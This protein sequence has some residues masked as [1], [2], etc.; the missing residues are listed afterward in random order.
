[1]TARPFARKALLPALL[2][3]GA[4]H[5]AAQQREPV[6]TTVGVPAHLDGVVLPGSE[7]EAVP[8]TQTSKVVVRIADVN[9]HG[10]AHRYDLEFVGLEAGEYDL[11]AFLQRKDR[12][13]NGPLPPLP[14][15]VASVLPAGKVKPDDLPAVPVRRLGGYQ[16]ELWVLAALWVVGLLLILFVGRKR[17]AVAAAA[18]PPLTLADRLRPLVGEAIAGALPEARRHELERLLLA[19]WRRRLGLQDRPVKDAIAAMRQHDEAGALLREL[20]RWLHAPPAR[21][22]TVDV[23]ALLAPYENLPATAAEESVA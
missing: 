9:V 18:A 12:T 19:Y 23:Q 3:L 15:V 8:G 13:E 14:I 21:R 6:R 4:G 16:T 11:G 2:L 5:L 22:G 17:R 10:T 20:E 7:F 1:M